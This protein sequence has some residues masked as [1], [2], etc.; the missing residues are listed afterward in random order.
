MD[1]SSAVWVFILLIVIIVIIIW[2]VWAS[3]RR[4]APGSA[5]SSDAQCGSGNCA[6]RAPLL[7]SPTV[8]CVGAK[9]TDPNG[10]VYCQG[11]Q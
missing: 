11:V 8:C 10:V 9:T 3:R 6:A 7:G 1:G 5:C 4:L 2:A